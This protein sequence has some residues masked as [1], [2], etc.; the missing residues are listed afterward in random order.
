MNLLIK[1]YI[2]DQRDLFESQGWERNFTS[3]VGSFYKLK[4]KNYKQT[5][6]V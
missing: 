4:Y 3:Y 1:I 5:L 6:Y 2:A